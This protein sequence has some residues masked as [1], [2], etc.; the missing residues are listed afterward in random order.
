MSLV[1]PDSVRFL[2]SLAAGVIARFAYVWRAPRFLPLLAAAALVSCG[3]P[4]MEHSFEKAAVIGEIEAGRTLYRLR[5]GDIIQIDVF[6]E[7]LMT[8]RQ[9]VLADG[10]INVGLVGSLEVGG[11]TVE[12]AR[13]QIAKK[14]D[15][16]YLVHPQVNLT[17]LA[18]SPRRFTVWGNVN[19]A[20]TYV[21]P[22]EETMVLPEA[23][24][25]AG[26]QTS[27]GNLKKVLITRRVGG[28]VRQIQV[29]SLAPEMQ[30]FK[31][32]EGDIIFVTE[33]KF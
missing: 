23:I 31:I 17:V 9:R 3:T 7:P 28:K 12:E 6:Q 26:G 19:N 22:P 29:N 20:A 32:R 33:T 10:T 24:A 4:Q 8:T 2:R 15:G 16:T 5:P 14:L 27:I 13:S 18:Y 25:M 11:Q 30:S 21:I 1:C